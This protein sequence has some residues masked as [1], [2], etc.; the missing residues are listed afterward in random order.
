V[1]TAGQAFPGANFLFV[2]APLLA[3]PL[4]KEIKQVSL[5][6]ATTIRLKYDRR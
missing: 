1:L 4:L 2:A 6:P 3:A 5:L